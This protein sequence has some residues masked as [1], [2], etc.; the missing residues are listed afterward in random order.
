MIQTT[1]SNEEILDAFEILKNP[2][3]IQG[4]TIIQYFFFNLYFWEIVK[5]FH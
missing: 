2:F 4:L 3:K 5:I 1:N